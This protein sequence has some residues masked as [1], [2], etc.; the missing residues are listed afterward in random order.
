MASRGRAARGLA[1]GRGDLDIGDDRLADAMIEVL[2]NVVSPADHDRERVGVEFMPRIRHHLPGDAANVAA[3]E[4]APALQRSGSRCASAS[5]ATQPVEP[6][7]RGLRQPTERSGADGDAVLV[8][9]GRTFLGRAAIRMVDCLLDHRQNPRV[10]I[11]GRLR[12]RLSVIDRR[13]AARQRGSR[14]GVDDID[15]GDLAIEERRK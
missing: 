15:A 8:R 4:H 11:V 1:S 14:I 12:D 3:L 6:P 7:R 2:E 10:D 9:D 13:L 5:I